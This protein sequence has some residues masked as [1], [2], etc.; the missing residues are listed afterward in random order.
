MIKEKCKVPLIDYP[1][2]PLSM[3]SLLALWLA[4]SINSVAVAQQTASMAE[5]F[6]GTL[7]SELTLRI[8]NNYLVDIDQPA[9]GGDP[10]Q[11]LIYGVENEIALAADTDGDFFDELILRR[12][13][14]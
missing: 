2:R 7:T 9:N 6:G 13:G 11:I 12:G 14:N 4:G 1:L 8:L 10:D 3:G 5:L